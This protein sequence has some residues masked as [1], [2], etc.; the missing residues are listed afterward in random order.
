M[1][2]LEQCS[3]SPPGTR[4]SVEDNRDDEGCESCEV[5]YG[6]LRGDCVLDVDIDDNPRI[7]ERDLGL[8]LDLLELERDFMVQML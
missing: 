1:E 7:Y 5:A 3:S 6:V 2:G 8:K 4:V